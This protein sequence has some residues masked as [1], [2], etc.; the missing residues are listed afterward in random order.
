MAKYVI[1][2]LDGTLCDHK[3][4]IHHSW[5]GN[6]NEYNS[7]C[8]YD[9]YNTSVFYFLSSLIIDQNFEIIFLTGRSDK[10]EKETEKWLNNYFVS[11]GYHLLMREEGNFTPAADFKKNKLMCC[12]FNIN[13]MYYALDDDE[14]CVEMFKAIGIKKVIHIKG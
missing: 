10:F 11:T 14:S 9:G 2:D 4:R 6:W 13:D 3:H 12:G 7:L 8:I 5:L 1:C